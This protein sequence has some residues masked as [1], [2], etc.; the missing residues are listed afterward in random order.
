[1]HYRG[2]EGVG[3]N[4]ETIVLVVPHPLHRATPPDYRVMFVE[5]F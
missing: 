1:M 3:Y 5:F 4:R 2:K